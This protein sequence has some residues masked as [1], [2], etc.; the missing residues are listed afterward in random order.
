[1]AEH[2]PALAQQS[3]RELETI[4]GEKVRVARD[5][6]REASKAFE[7]TWNENFDI[8]LASDPTLAIQQARKVESAA[9]KEYMRVLKIFTN[10]IVHNRIPGKDQN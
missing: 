9:L 1:M 2:E 5:L 3:K 7:L 8:H 4:W 10:L 6:Y